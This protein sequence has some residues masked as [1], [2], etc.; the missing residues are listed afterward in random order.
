[1]NRFLIFAV[2][3]LLFS[4]NVFAETLT[5]PI[6]GLITPLPYPV[7]IESEFDETWFE[8]SS[9][10]YNHKIARLACILADVSYVDARAEKNALLGCYDALKIEK[11]D[12]EIDYAPNYQGDN[13]QAAYSFALRKNA[14]GN[15]IVFVVIR[16]TPLSANEWISNLN[17][18]DSTKQEEIFHEGFKRTTERIFARFRAFLSEKKIDLK[19][20]S[21]LVTGHSRGAAIANLFAASISQ[22]LDFDTNRVFAY[23]FATPNVTTAQNADDEKF[24]YIWN[25]ESEEDIVQ[26]V[27]PERG[28]WRF[29]K[30][31]KVRMLPS[32][33]KFGEDEYESK[34]AKMNK[35]F[36]K[37]MLR[38]YEPFKIG[39]FIPI[40][41]TRLLTKLNHTVESYY[42]FFGVRK[43][44]WIFWRIFPE[45]PKKID[46][47]NE[48]QEKITLQFT[49][50][51]NCETYLSW[52]LAL[53][54]NEL[55]GTNGSLE[56]RITGSADCAVYDLDGNLLATVKNGYT[57]YKET[58]API[59]ALSYPERTFVGFPQNQGFRVV[60]QKESLIPTPISI[61]LNRYD[62][63]GIL[64]NSTKPKRHWLF[65]G[66]ALDFFSDEKNDSLDF[67]LEKT[68]PSS[69]LRR[70]WKL[71]FSPEISFSP[72]NSLDFGLNAGTRHLHALALISPPIVKDKTRLS[73]GLATEAN[74]WARFYADVAA[75]ATILWE[76]GEKDV[77]MSSRFSLA[78]RMVNR[79]EIFAALRLDFAD[80][81][82]PTFSFG[83][84]F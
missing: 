50:M 46:E 22:N 71:Y 70:G 67:S 45:N 82:E 56:F 41:I 11:K 80:Q 33:W 76:D 64:Q 42:G 60:F 72:K 10:E 81:T 54:E 31:G 7:E 4:K 5:F 8:K 17:I 69:D 53:D 55:F 9:F 2:S 13:D 34:K 65:C 21:I 63:R 40:Q 84:R 59:G 19:K 28:E 74:V 51:H 24:G 73:M 16:G 68:K 75:L 48:T 47:K 36:C 29:R 1:M 27:P 20:T 25:I 79:A 23:T 38:E 83:L 58:F 18:A 12:A 52:L 32:R 61:S 62:E 14:N 78:F 39:A 66:T 6:K 44:D 57:Q 35:I 77:F 26:S 30:F 37:I 3:A 15:F 43:T 49:D